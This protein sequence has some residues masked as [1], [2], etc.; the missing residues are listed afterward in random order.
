[1]DVVLLFVHGRSSLTCLH[2]VLVAMGVSAAVA[3]WIGST[4]SRARFSRMNAFDPSAFERIPNAVPN[5]DNNSAALAQISK[6]VFYW[7]NVDASRFNAR[8]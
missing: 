6:S 2:D 7:K 1:M 5:T 3:K 8:V 4:M